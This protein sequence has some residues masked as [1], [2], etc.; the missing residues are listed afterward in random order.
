MN[1]IL[2][3]LSGTGFPAVKWADIGLGNHIVGTLIDV[4]T[5]AVKGQVERRPVV[6]P[7]RDRTAGRYTTD[8]VGRY[9]ESARFGDQGRGPFA[10]SEREDP[11]RREV[12]RQVGLV[13]TAEAGRTFADASVQSEVRTAGRQ[14]HGCVRNLLSLARIETTLRVISMRAPT[15]V[16]GQ[17]RAG[18]GSCRSAHTDTDKRTTVST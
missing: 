11:A 3:E 2:D 12:D 14:R 8:A 7:V 6:T 15:R 10:R 16:Q 9:L 17:T 4:P 1:D 5:K 18:P 13:R